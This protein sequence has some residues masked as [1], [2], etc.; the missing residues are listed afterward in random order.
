MLEAFVILTRGGFVLWAW[1]FTLYVSPSF[2]STAFS[3]SSA[4]STATATAINAAVT[5]LIHN[6]LIEEKGGSNV[7]HPPNSQYELRW[8]AENHMGLLFVA[9]YAKSLYLTYIEELLESVKKSF[10][11]LY[12]EMRGKDAEAAVAG[13]YHM[14][15]DE[16]F[17]KIRTRLEHKDLESRNSKALRS[18]SS[19]DAP[20]GVTG[21]SNHAANGG[22]ESQ[23]D[24]DELAAV[25]SGS[26]GGLRGKLPPP[27][28]R[29]GHRGKAGA[30]ASRAAPSPPAEK[31][32][33][34]PRVWEDG[35]VSKQMEQELDRSKTVDTDGE[36]MDERQ[37]GALRSQWIDEASL[38]RKTA[39][40]YYE[41]ADLVAAA[42]AARRVQGTGTDADDEDES[43]DEA[44]GVNG[45]NSIAASSS[46]GVFSFFRSMA[47]GGRTLS[48]A[49]LHPIMV[50][51]KEHLINK[52]V[53]ADIAQNLCDSVM[54]ALV[55]QK[56]GSFQRITAV[57]NDQIELS[58]QRILTPKSSTD[59]LRDI[60][61]ARAERRPYTIVFCG[62]NG[63]G[64][65]TN[66][67]KVVFLL[68]Q[69]GCKPLIVGGDTFRS[70][71]V[72]QLKVHA[73]NLN[74][75]S[76]GSKV[77]LYEKGYGKDP[78]GIAKE[79]IA[80]ATA[81][82]FDVVL[83]DTAGRMQDNEPLM[84]ALA[85]L[86]TMNS[87]DKIIFVGEALVGNE[88]VDQLTKFNRALR[89]FSGVQ[90]PRQID[91]IILTKFDT[92]DEKV[93][94]ALSMTYI[95]GQP[96]LFVGTGQTYTD[97]KRLN[98]R[99]IVQTLLR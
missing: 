79:A 70:G 61:A 89:D 76:S 67:A 5:A 31:K 41:A 96:I 51:V 10:V 6:V 66:L 80:Y 23:S 75:L 77:E 98:V 86:V 94:A 74:A 93:G 8:K 60:F 59:V 17:N 18:Q 38:G 11:A 3:L 12:T 50:K 47:A 88:A 13:D 20:F 28:G 43:Q 36:E 90:N 69:N 33:R 95:T 82:G 55:G 37:Q 57:V 62:V 92:I 30:M 46:S 91:G 27:R 40:G 29:G 99:A 32:K 53:A 1:P 64:K 21:P 71:A 84:R 56:I 2:A 83:V 15:F 7:Y 25:S 87:P 35:K 72:E 78:A 22:T 14:A 97:L 49:D 48:E 45:T 9:V 34:G 81:N 85:K 73:R 24:V 26:P 4:A 44:E 68:Q 54:K 63:V 42:P 39:D 58:L 52:N 19:K 16:K 65:S